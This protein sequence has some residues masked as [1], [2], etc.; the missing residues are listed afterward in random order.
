MLQRLVPKLTVANVLSPDGS[1]SQR[2]TCVPVRF[3]L[4]YGKCLPILTGDEKDT[5]ATE[6]TDE[7]IMFQTCTQEPG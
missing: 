6:K 4:S 2:R 5:E 3:Q 7:A 1:D